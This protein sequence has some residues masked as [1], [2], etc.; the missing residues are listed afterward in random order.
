MIELSDFAQAVAFP[1]SHSTAM[2]H[3]DGAKDE[4]RRREHLRYGSK[5]ILKT[6]ITCICRAYVH[7]SAT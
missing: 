7:R 6:G 2:R 4:G 1:I 5:S 3:R